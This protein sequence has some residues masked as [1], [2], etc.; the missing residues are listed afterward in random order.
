MVH[1]QLPLPSQ[2]VV[3]TLQEQGK[4]THTR[5]EGATVGCV[6]WIV[7]SSMLLERVDVEKSNC[8]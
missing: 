7:P 4:W 3:A 2:W 1:C 5:L 8:R 6:P